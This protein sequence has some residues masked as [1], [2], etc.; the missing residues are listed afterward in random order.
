MPK[1]GLDFYC[2]LKAYAGTERF[3]H[4]V[5][6]LQERFGSVSLPVMLRL[7][8]SAR[9][10]RPRV[11]IERRMLETMMISRARR[12]LAIQSELACWSVD[13]IF[14]SQVRGLPNFERMPFLPVLP[15]LCF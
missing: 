4:A 13:I 10:A 9:Q 15:F 14:Q 12:K 8:Q 3:K 1:G 5:E 6:R 11:T 2:A 7:I